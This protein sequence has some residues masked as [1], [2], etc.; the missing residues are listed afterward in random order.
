MSTW[1]TAARQPPSAARVSLRHCAAD[2][3]RLRAPLEQPVWGVL[4]PAVPPQTGPAHASGSCSIAPSTPPG[5][6]RTWRRSPTRSTRPAASAYRSSPR[7]CGMLYGRSK[8][9]GADA[10]ITTVLAAGNTISQ[11][12]PAGTTKRGTCA[13]AT[14][15]PILQG[16][17]LTWDRTSWAASDGGA[18]R[19]DVRRRW[20]FRSST[21]GSSPVLSRSRK[22]MLMA[23]RPMSLIMNAVAASPRLRST[24]L[25]CDTSPSSSGASRS[26]C[27]AFVKHARI[28]NA[29]GLDTP[30]SVIKLL[31]AMRAAITTWCAGRDRE[32]DPRSD[33]GR[34]STLRQAMP[35]I[36]ALIAAGGQDPE[37]LTASS[38]PASRSAFRLG[39]TGGGWPST[40]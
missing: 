22:P 39:C 6:P 29:V 18:A 21:A 1:P 9:L 26:C 14:D 8:Y 12:Q 25:A 20:R 35:L 33:R 31:R 24:T 15:I 4:H 5:T 30:V 13:L 17:C 2:R 34:A 32:A 11:L 38:C 3:S 28:G 23:C 7:R 10:L 16:L 19:L 40:C 37:W 27:G 36:H